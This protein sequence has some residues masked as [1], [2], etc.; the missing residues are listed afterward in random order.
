MFFTG[1]YATGHK[2]YNKL[3]PKMIPVGLELGGKD[4]LYITD[5]I[6]DIKVLPQMLLKEHFIIA[7]KAVVPLSVFMFMKM[8]TMIL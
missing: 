8:F 5:S 6:S 1:S 2:I 3:A 7:D 4:P